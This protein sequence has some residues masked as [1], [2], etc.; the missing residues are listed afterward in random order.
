MKIIIPF[1]ETKEKICPSFGRAPYFGTIDSETGETIVLDNPAANAEGGAGIK[2]A[3]FV[4]DQ[5]PDVIL[6]PRAGKN[7]A[8]VLSA[9]DIKIYKTEGDSVNEAIAAFKAGKL[10]ILTEFHA[11]FMH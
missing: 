7:A 2:A 9:T 3:Q 1:D 6:T 8:D 11:G 4:V 5:K 10:N